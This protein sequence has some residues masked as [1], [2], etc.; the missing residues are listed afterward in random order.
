MQVVI[1][2]NNI[3]RVPEIYY[4]FRNIRT[5]FSYF[6]IPYYYAVGRI[7]SA[8]QYSSNTFLNLEAFKYYVFK[9]TEVNKLASK[10]YCNYSF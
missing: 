6:V 3:L 10:R 2:D 1:F 8:A 7:P 4:I 9:I 5:A